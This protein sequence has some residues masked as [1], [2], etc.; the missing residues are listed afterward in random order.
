MTKS[1][2]L[3]NIVIMEYLRLP[4][5]ALDPIKQQLVSVSLPNIK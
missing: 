4:P 2:P 5:Q 3:F 1:V